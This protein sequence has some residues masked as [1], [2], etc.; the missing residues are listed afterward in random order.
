MWRKVG[1]YLEMCLDRPKAISWSIFVIRAVTI[2]DPAYS[3][4]TFSYSL[5]AKFEVLTALSIGRWYRTFRR[6]VVFALYKLI[7]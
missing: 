7:N 1:Q 6:S 2:Q 4:V 3:S 5:A